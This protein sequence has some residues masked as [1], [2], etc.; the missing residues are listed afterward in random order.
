MDVVCQ[1]IINQICATEVQH[2][3]RSDGVRDATFGQAVG[4][5]NNGSKI[6][7]GFISKL[8]ITG[9]SHKTK[10]QTVTD[11]SRRWEADISIYYA[12][13]QE[14]ITFDDEPFKDFERPPI[15]AVNDLRSQFATKFN[16]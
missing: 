14:V 10:K 8:T 2:L 6:A 5:N 13:V 7:N 16:V 9:F 4:Q 12:V 11:R 15:Q 1:E 3:L